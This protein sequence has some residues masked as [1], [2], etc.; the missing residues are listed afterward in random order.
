VSDGNKPVRVLYSFPLRLG[1]GRI[2]GIAW[3]QVNGI[4]TAGA[5]VLAFPASISRPVNPGVKVSST[6]A[7]GELRL[8]YRLVG[9][10]RAVALH[11]WI[12]ARRLEKLAGQ[13]DIIHAWPTGALET[14]KAAKRL[15]IPTVLERCNAHTRFAME[16]VQKECDRLGVALPPDH[17]HAYNEE[18]LRKEEEEY[19][20]AT[21]LLCP[22]DFVVKTFLDQGFAKEQLVRHTYGYDEK[23]YY[24]SRGPREPKRGLTMLFVGV[25]AVRKGVHYALEAWLKSS[26]SK[27]GT[28]QIA[29]EFL[30]AYQEKLA[31]LLAHPSVKVLGHRNDVPGLMRKSDILVLPSIEEG[32][33]LVI[34]E[35]MGSG[36]VPLASEACTEICSHMKTGL[37]HRVGDVEALTQH[38]TMLH[39]DRALLEKLRAASLEAAPT[40]TWTAAGRMLLEA[41]RETLDEYRGGMA[42]ESDPTHK[43][44]YAQS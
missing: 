43:S 25:C 18:K 39:E 33:G 37:M 9:T 2:C 15:G 19:A 3:Q 11:D 1:V 10:T 14:L 4:S 28:F 13:I 40:F 29:G 23:V 38:I 36:S 31:P 32:F 20:L 26:A 24:P 44:A 30:P 41:Y 5:E 6:L 27:D 17:E 34:A 7:R 21:R 8:P 16:V 42:K 12:V 35:A 22:C